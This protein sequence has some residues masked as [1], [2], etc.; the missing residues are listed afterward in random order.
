MTPW[1]RRNLLA[2]ALAG[3]GT[4]FSQSAHALPSRAGLKDYAAES[5]LVFGS[6]IS[7][8]N[9]PLPECRALYERECRIVTTD[10]AL[11]FAILRPRPEVFNFEPADALIDWAGRNGL[12]VRGHTLI[13]ND[14]NGD[15]LKGR[16][17]AEITRVFDEHI[18]RVVS[19]YVGRIHTWDVVN[20]PF[21]P[22]HGA[23]GGY[24]RGPWFDA[25]G[26]GYVDRAFRRVR[27]IDKTA[28]L[29]LN[30]AMVDNDH[31]FGQ[32]IRPRLAALTSDLR[33]RGT[34]F[35]VVGLQCH[36]QPA[37]PHDYPKFGEYMRLLTA[38]DVDLDVTEFDVNDAGFPAPITE[39]DALVAGYAQE[40][41]KPALAVPRLKMFI[42]W[43]LADH[44]SW[45]WHRVADVSPA[46]PRLPRPLPFDENLARKP[47]WYA[48]AR[49]F[50]ARATT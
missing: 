19:R 10:L 18:E 35:D 15:W 50:D 38:Q 41:L 16:S 46:S 30:E 3:A 17:S 11:K 23:P 43:E 39:R 22:G 31:E 34:P 2:S 7:L 5:G 13:W 14:N 40:F 20:E 36:L 29:C 47:L 8:E 21:W 33:Q 49:A 27:A 45:L 32:S 1:T 24:R 42:T 25:M 9:F 44:W 12:L 4:A 48:L 6:A 28:R 26:P 37:W